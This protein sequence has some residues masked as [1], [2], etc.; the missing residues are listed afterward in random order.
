L[1]KEQVIAVSVMIEKEVICLARYLVTCRSNPAAPLPK[2]PDEY[3]K[4]MEQVWAGFDDGMK[5][6]IIKDIGLFLD[7][8]WDGYAIVEG[9]GADILKGN[10]TFFPYWLTDTREIISYEKARK[11]SKAL[12]EAQ[13]EAAKK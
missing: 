5:K 7:G 11:I 4:L 13:K 10:I 6:G 9:E 2:D 12:I 3:S 8:H 1:D